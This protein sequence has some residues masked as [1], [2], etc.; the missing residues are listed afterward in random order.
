MLL[1]A[2]S[3]KS[4]SKIL[5]VEGKCGFLMWLLHACHLCMSNRVPLWW[6][7]ISSPRLFSLAQW[8]SERKR[9]IGM[10]PC[11]CLKASVVSLHSVFHFSCTIMKELFLILASIQ[12]DS[13]GMVFSLIRGRSPCYDGV[14]KLMSS[15]SWTVSS[16]CRLRIGKGYTVHQTEIRHVGFQEDLSQEKRNSIFP[17]VLS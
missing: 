13:P 17:A 4:S 10:I 3:A 14:I 11:C 2:G 12:A 1:L 5:L 16:S 7:Y 6:L 8:L 9:N 15:F